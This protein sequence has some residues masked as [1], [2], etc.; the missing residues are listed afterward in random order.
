MARVGVA[1]SPLI[2]LLEDVWVNLPCVV[3]SLV[4]LGAGLSASLLP[5]TYNV[6]LP[7]TIEDVEQT[8][9]WALM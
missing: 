4:A 8:K 7:E 5:E 9:Y 6:C 2:M 3:F 1:V